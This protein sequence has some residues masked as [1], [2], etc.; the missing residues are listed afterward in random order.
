MHWLVKTDNVAN[1]LLSADGQRG[2]DGDSFN[3]FVDGVAKRAIPRLTNGTY[4]VPVVHPGHGGWNVNRR[5]ASGQ[6]V[7]DQ[8]IADWSVALQFV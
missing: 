8:N 3:N 4:S 7:D 6:S 2:S 1:A 5:R